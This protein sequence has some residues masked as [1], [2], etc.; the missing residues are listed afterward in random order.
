MR[1]L[2]RLGGS[3]PALSLELATAGNLAFPDSPDAAERAF[4]ITKSLTNLNRFED[5]REQARQMVKAYPDTPY[6]AD[7]ARHL[8]SVPFSTDRPRSEAD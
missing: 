8:L 4:I 5:A 6:S 3:Q 2:R 1:E 7:V